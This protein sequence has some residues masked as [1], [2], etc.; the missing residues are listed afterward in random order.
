MIN[1]II[2]NI[3]T[4]LATTVSMGA[5]PLLCFIAYQVDPSLAL[6]GLGLGVVAGPIIAVTLIDMIVDWLV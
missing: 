2:I 3:T 6:A 5:G 4:L 1:N